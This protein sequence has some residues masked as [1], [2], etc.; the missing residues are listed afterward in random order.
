MAKYSPRGGFTL[1]EMVVVLVVI[2]VLTHLA[3]RELS[4]VR[5]AQLRKAADRQLESLR[6]CVWS[7]SA[8]GE[9]EGFLSDIGRLPRLVSAT[10]SDGTTVGTLSE[11]WKCPDG[12]PEYALLPATNRALYAAG[13]DSAALASMGKGVFVPAGWRGPYLRMPFGKD[14]LLDPWGNPLES[15]DDAGFRRVAVSNGV[16]VAVSHFG[17]D[18]RPDGQF[19]PG[20]PNAR[21]STVSLVP[22]GG[23]KCRLVVSAEIAGAS[24]FA[25][26]IDWAWYGP[27]GGQITGAVKR[28]AYPAPAEFD[29]LTPGVRIVKDSVSGIARRVVIRPGDNLMQFKMAA[30]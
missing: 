11:L 30:P 4:H 3:V 21:D 29:G 17:S 19:K 13:A 28:V 2:A 8:D 1:I 27:A 9:P 5:A 6:D 10:N 25:G 22:Q 15:E 18:A 7:V 12:M 16:A 26:D 20:S 24:P 23:T 14:R